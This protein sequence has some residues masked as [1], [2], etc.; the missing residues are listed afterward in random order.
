MEMAGKGERGFHLSL[1][2]RWTRSVGWG[3]LSQNDPHPA[4]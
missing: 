1:V 3:L 2:G 4:V